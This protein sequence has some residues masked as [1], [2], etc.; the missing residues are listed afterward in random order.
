[1]KPRDAEGI[2]DEVMALFDKLVKGIPLSEYRAAME[3]LKDEFA[4]RIE[5]SQQMDGDTE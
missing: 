1:M 2:R 4:M 3:E 5:A